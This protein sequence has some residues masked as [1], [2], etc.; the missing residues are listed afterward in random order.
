MAKVAEI[1]DALF[2]LAP[3][4]LAAEGDNIGLQVG[5]PAAEVRKAIVGIDVTAA[6]IRKAR[7]SRAQL[8]VV[9]HPLIFS[10]LS[11]LSLDSYP[12][13]LVAEALRAHLA[14]VTMHTNL[15]FAPG[16][17][18]DRLAQVAGLQDV[19]PL[20]P[21]GK[22]SL[23]KVVVFVP[24]QSQ[25]RVRQAMA[26]AGAG[27]IGKYRECSFRAPGT[28]TFRP[29]PGAHPRSGK[30]G[31]LEE[32]REERLEVLVER[33]RLAGVLEAMKAAHPYEE[34]A[35]DVY[36]LENYFPGAGE[37]RVGRL[38]RSISLKTFAGRVKKSLKAGPVQITGEPDCR[39]T[40]VAVGAG[41]VRG[42]VEAARRVG[43]EAL[44]AGEIPHHERLEAQEEGL[45]VIEAGH[46]ASERP[47]VWVLAEWLE[48]AFANRLK[49][50]RFEPGACP[51]RLVL[52]VAEGSRR[53]GKG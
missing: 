47:A 9:H 44:L 3:S 53:E 23:L 25:A 37:G 11:C 51:E 2:A 40:K 10:P 7:A 4:Q 48:K 42:M 28:G 46:E 33:P 34:A 41:S 35:Y 18:N 12:S 1:I 43:A 5:D 26:A 15:D 27:E 6:L 38:T 49:V 21:W 19:R 22:G 29:L 14:I 8:A 39:I 20:S 50:I 52:S 45:A 24:L 30:V 36:P 32:V 16:G 13:R 31:R 17:V